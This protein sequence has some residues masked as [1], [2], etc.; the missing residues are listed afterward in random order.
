M[1]VHEF[2]HLYDVE[3]HYGAQGPSTQDMINEGRIGYS[4]NCIHGENRNNPDVYENLVLCDGCRAEIESY[5]WKYN[6]ENGGN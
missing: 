4:E 6:Y 1:F 3:D 5:L 2:N